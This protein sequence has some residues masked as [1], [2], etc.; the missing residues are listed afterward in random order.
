MNPSVP[1]IVAY[2]AL[3]ALGVEVAL[4]LGY[5][6]WK[7]IGKMRKDIGICGLLIS[8]GFLHSMAVKPSK[9]KVTWDDYLEDNGSV[10]ATNTTEVTGLRLKW[11]KT[12]TEL[13]DEQDLHISARDYGTSG[14]WISIATTKVNAFEWF[15]LMGDATNYEYY[16]WHEWSPPTPVHTN[17]IW[18][19]NVVEKAKNSGFDK[20]VIINSRFVIDG[21]VVAPKEEK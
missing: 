19:G 12:R 6:C 10:Y 1:N 18:N 11:K 16:V 17:V 21:K 8:F 13:P 5:V 14:E 4:G 2:C 9:P 15:K 7:G 20:L 3:C